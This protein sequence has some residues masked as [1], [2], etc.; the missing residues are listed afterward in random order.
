MYRPFTI[1]ITEADRYYNVGIA[2]MLSKKWVEGITFFTGAITRNNRYAKAIHQRALCYIELEKYANA[3][4]DLDEILKNPNM[5]IP[6]VT[7]RDEILKIKEGIEQKIKT[8]QPPPN[9]TFTDKPPEG[10]I[11]P[12]PIIKR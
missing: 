8:L 1:N 6:T 9:I 5:Q 2:N 3:L 10:L 7:F 11:K 12:T 4:T